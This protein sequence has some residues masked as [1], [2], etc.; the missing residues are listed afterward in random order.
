MRQEEVRHCLDI[1]YLVMPAYNEEET[2]EEVVR[3]W[4]PV[5]KGKHPASKMVIADSGSRDR[6]H[7]ILTGLKEELPQ[8]E[9]LPTRERQHGPKLLALYRYA[10]EQGADYIFQTDS[11]GQ[12]DPAEFDGFWRRRRDFDA[13][14]G[15]RRVRG[16]GR[17]RALVEQV[18]CLLLRCVFGVRVPDAN[19]PFRLM[20]ASLAARYIRRLP[21]DY[22]LPNI[23]LTAYFAYYGERI[24]FRTIRF[25]PRQGG[26]S[27]I[28][29]G[30]IVG[31]GWRALRDFRRFKMDMQGTASVIRL[32]PG[33]GTRKG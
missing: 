18:V 5:L 23:M 6:T 30:E 29:I 31:I 17:L 10:I 13:I 14:L 27:S 19:A 32:R 24:C 15:Y 26:V 7:A 25:R 20:K 22:N 8:L 4:Y 2:I 12:T 9:L 16:D 1:L 3:A 28:H 33:R 11:D 21:E